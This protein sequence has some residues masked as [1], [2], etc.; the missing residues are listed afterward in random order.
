MLKISRDQVFSTGD[1]KLMTAVAEVALGAVQASV[2]HENAVASALVA[3]EHQ[4]A[5]ELAQLVLP[6]SQ[7]NLAGAAIFARSDPAREAGGDFYCFDEVDG[8]VLFAVGDVSGKGLPA[9]VTMTTVVSAAMAAF[10][11]KGSLG[12]TSVLRYIDRWLYQSLDDAAMFVT[13][14]VGSYLSLI[15]I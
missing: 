14:L 8:R 7:P 13:L 9:A 1:R 2:M 3:Q 12:P 10:A 15:H 5:S 11:S 6:S 4:T